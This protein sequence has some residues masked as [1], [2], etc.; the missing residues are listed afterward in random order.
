MHWE[1]IPDYVTDGSLKT[2]FAAVLEHYCYG[3]MGP[4]VIVVLTPADGQPKDV[5]LFR[6]TLHVGGP[7]VEDVDITAKYWAAGQPSWYGEEFNGVT[8]H[9][10]YEFTVDIDSQVESIDRIEIRI[11]ALSYG[12]GPGPATNN[13]IGIA[14]VDVACGPDL[15]VDNVKIIET[16]IEVGEKIHVS[17][18]IRNAGSE[19]APPPVKVRFLYYKVDPEAPHDPDRRTLLHTSDKFIKGGL[20]VLGPGET[21]NQIDYEGFTVPEIAL[22]Q[23]E[24]VVDPPE[25]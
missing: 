17:A 7:P 11:N 1:G 5:D 6:V 22:Y 2:S 9:D 14:E 4:E 24:V 13:P 15:V 16:R 23:V 8:I 25:E 10:G 18:E 19:D 20:S 21:W 12:D 3:I